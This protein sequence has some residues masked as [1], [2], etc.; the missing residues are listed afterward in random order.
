MSSY[1]K[2]SMRHILYIHPKESKIINS[3]EWR[4][5]KYIIFITLAVGAVNNLPSG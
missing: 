3:R 4:M 1:I 5:S 2:L